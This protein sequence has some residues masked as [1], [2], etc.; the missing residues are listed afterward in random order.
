M[1]ASASIEVAK[2]ESLN[3]QLDGSVEFDSLTLKLYA[4]DASVY[5]RFQ[6][7]SRFQKQIATFKN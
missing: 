7:P 2:L 6:P 4:T 3:R 1:S 5:N